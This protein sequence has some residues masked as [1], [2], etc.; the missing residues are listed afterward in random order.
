M[1]EFWNLSWLWGIRRLSPAAG[2]FGKT[3]NGEIIAIGL[4]MTSQ[5]RLRC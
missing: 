2:D 1:R 4:A 3:D 5:G